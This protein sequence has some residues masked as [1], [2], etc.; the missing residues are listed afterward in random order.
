[1]CVILRPLRSPGAAT[2]AEC[3]RASGAGC[4]FSTAGAKWLRSEGQ[5]VAPRLKPTVGAP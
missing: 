1:M 2:A 4:G 5:G 3:S